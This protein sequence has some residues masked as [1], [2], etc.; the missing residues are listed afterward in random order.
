MKGAERTVSYGDGGAP[1]I[2]T[3]EAPHV[4][5]AVHCGQPLTPPTRHSLVDVDEAIVGRGAP[6]CERTTD[7]GRAVLNIKLPDDQM[8]ATHL[9]LRRGGDGWI[10][11]DLESKNGTFLNGSAVA[12]APVLDNDIVEAGATLLVF[13][14]ATQL[15]F[16][17]AAD[18]NA[19]DAPHPGLATLNIDLQRTFEA[20]ARFAQTSTPILLL[21]ETGTGKEVTARAIHELSQRQGPFVAIN[22]GGL[23]TTLAE[24]E[25]FGHCRGAFSGAVADHVGRIRAA[26]G[27]TLF[28]DEIGDMPLA[29]Q[30]KLLRVLQEHEVVPVGATHAQTIDVRFVAA[31]NR[32]LPAL[33][34]SGAFRPDL[35]ARLAGFECLLPPL[36]N[37]REDIGIL[38]AALLRKHL[39][40]RATEISLHRHAARALAL[41]H[42]PRNIRELDH[43]L[44]AAVTM[45]EPC[46]HLEQI[47]FPQGMRVPETT[48][49]PV[50][51]DDNLREELI[52]LLRR[53]TGNVSAVARDLNKARIQIRR[54]CKRL[55]VD[56][57]RFRQ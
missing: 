42:W 27:G 19:D 6:H 55:N 10:V 18:A 28:L 17:E 4:T 16:R 48:T 12:T 53:H 20:L 45:A 35:Y 52:T 7:S 56:P 47:H 11:D 34:Q 33:S 32:D 13:R 54:W 5:L 1:K 38:I 15:Q 37:R 49:R 39:G 57:D 46:Q 22:C 14:E 25:L 41:H 36:R 43:A 3:F 9:R 40:T 26:E 21:G 8:S 31:T 24:S 44:A 30:V 29:L 51:V 50:S 2:T 23:A